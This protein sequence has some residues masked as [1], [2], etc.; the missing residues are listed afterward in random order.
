[1]RERF[2]VFDFVRYFHEAFGVPI[3]V[4]TEAESWVGFSEGALLTDE[5]FDHLLRPWI[6]T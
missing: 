1:L 6:H 5:D 3:K 4:L 2:S